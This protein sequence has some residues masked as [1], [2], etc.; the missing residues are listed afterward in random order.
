MALCG[1]AVPQAWAQRVEPLVSAKFSQSAP[2]NNACPEGY[3]AGCGPV[4]LAQI[5]ATYRQ[6]ATGYGSVVYKSGGLADSVRVDFSRTAFDWDHILD[7]YKTGSYTQ[8]EADAVAGLVFACG[9]ATYAQYGPSTSI[10]NYG[11]ML[12]GMQHFLHFSPDGRYLHRAYYSTAEWLEMLDGQLQAGHPVFYRGSWLFNGGN[13]GHMFVVDGT[14]GEGRYHI[15]FGHGGSGDKFA[16]LNIINQSGNY[17]GGRGVCY[18]ATQAMVVNC[19]PTPDATDYP[20]QRC[21]LTEPVVLNG[22]STLRSVSVGLGES[23][24]LSCLLMNCS[25]QRATI[26]YGWGLERDGEFLG[27]L[28]QRTYSL[29]AG[30]RFTAR[31]HL[32]VTIPADL[33]RGTYRLV[34]YSCSDLEPDWAPVWADARPAVDLYVSGRQA[35]V[36]IPDPHDGDPQLYLG[37]EIAEVPN[38]MA[39]TVPGRSF[40]LQMRNETTNNYQDVVRLEIEAEGE[41]YTFETTLP[42]YSQTETEFQV[43]VPQS[44]VDLAGKQISAVRASYRFGPDGSF[45]PLTTEKP[46]SVDG[47]Q[48]G[49][50]ED[51]SVYSLQGILQ[52]RIPA[53]RVAEMYGQVLS[54]LPHGVYVIKE[55]RKSRKIKI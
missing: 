35:T 32:P 46:T 8:E 11:R 48:A 41:T 26:Q 25:G 7:Q 15:N 14:D 45:F 2:Y 51:V 6:P 22:D 55:G 12:Y 29:G 16:D 23:V 5:L 53:A 44:E 37:G 42:V 3:A 36:A 49:G 30:Y 31:R 33:E 52:A 28:A 47:V 1:L 39:A 50:A 40:S 27:M 4:A 10:N 13:V 54:A 21:I 17:P 19:F 9:A 38:E 43:L 20:E 34:L 18:N 24:T